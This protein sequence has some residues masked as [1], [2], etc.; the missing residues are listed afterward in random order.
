M[1]EDTHRGAGPV[2]LASAAKQT[3]MTGANQDGTAAYRND[4]ATPG[5]PLWGFREYCRTIAELRDA[6][7]AVEDVA[8]HVTSR[9]YELAEAAERDELRRAALA[10]Q[11]TGNHPTLAANHTTLAADL[12]LLMTSTA[13]LAS[14]VNDACEIAH[15]GG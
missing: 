14:A 10:V 7:K 15:I 3:S 9:A 1:M 11:G 13:A 5:S 2:M 4:N 6:A 8:S 12:D